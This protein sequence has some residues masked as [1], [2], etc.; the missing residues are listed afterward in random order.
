MAAISS[1]G[2]TPSRDQEHRD[3]RDPE[4]RRREHA[5]RDG[6]EAE[7]GCQAVAR[8]GRGDADD[9]AGEEADRIS[10]QAL[11]AGARAWLDL[12]V[13]RGVSQPSPSRA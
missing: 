5:D 11:L 1:G 3:E 2:P 9:A 10:L 8:G 6:D 12:H 7:R 4:D 13:E